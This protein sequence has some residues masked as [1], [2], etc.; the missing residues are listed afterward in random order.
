MPLFREPK[1]FVPPTDQDRVAIV[2]ATGSGKSTFAFWLFGETANYDR[3]PWIIIDYKGEEIV[4]ALLKNKDAFLVSLDKPVPTKPGIYVV[5]PT[6]RDPEQILNYLWLIYANGRCGVI[7]DELM[8]VPKQYDIHNNPVQA[9]LT[10]GRSKR[11]PL[12]LLAQRPARVNIST[13]SEATFIA[14]FRLY[15]KDDLIRVQEYIPENNPIFAD[16]K[17]LPRYYCKW[18]D[19]RREMALVLKPAPGASEIL[20]IVAHRVDRMRQHEKL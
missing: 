17:P 15:K 6:P 8:M 12:Y 2:G 9:L 5:R 11:I 3:M 20:D 4:Q 18:W 14:E 10:Q 13:F 19:S 7:F 16:R 1:T